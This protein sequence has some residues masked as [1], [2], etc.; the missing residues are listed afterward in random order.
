MRL[1]SVALLAGMVT[2]LVAVMIVDDRRLSGHMV[3]HLLL[4]EVAPAFLL[5]GR[6]ALH[7]LRALPSRPRRL[8]GRG[9]V[10]IGRCADP[11]ACLI[12]FALIVL[13]THVPVIF[14]FCARHVVAHIAEHGAYLFAGFMMWWPLFGEPNP[15]QRLGV[16][17]QLAYITVA[18]LPMT[19]LGAFLDRDQTLFYPAYAGPGAV[20]DQERAGAIMWVAGT[21]V[22]ACVGLGAVLASVLAAERRQRAR[23]LRR[24]AP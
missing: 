4:I 17:G 20:L 24:V 19:L 21:T 13:G 5:Y 7:A 22:M 15:R 9:L 11:V 3:Q 10:V 23:E 6:A 1:R 18:M 8:I 2:V 16:V 14:D 12:L